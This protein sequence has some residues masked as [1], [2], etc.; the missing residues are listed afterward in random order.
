MLD[1]SNLTP[2]QKAF[3][4][5]MWENHQRESEQNNDSTKAFE[6]YISKRRAQEDDQAKAVE[7]LKSKMR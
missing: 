2:E 3:F 7:V 1:F 6:D 5:D 4:N